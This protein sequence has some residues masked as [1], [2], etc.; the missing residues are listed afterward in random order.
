MFSCSCIEKDNHNKCEKLE[1]FGFV[2]GVMMGC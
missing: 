1:K 2:I